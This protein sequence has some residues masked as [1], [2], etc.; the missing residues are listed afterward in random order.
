MDARIK[1]LNGKK[2]N[3]TEAVTV[4]SSKITYYQGAFACLNGGG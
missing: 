2:L 1:G 4:P 3:N